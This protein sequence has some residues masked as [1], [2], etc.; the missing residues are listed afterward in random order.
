MSRLNRR[1]FLQSSAALGGALLSA[2]A[3]RSA[4]AAPE[5]IDAPVVDQVVVHEI[6]DNQHNIFLRPR[7][8]PGLTVQHTGFPGALQGSIEHVLPRRAGW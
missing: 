4:P 2:G 7:K 6:S 5:R 8:R 3:G 1:R